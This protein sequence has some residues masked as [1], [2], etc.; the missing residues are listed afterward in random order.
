[1]SMS[2]KGLAKLMEEAGEVV[3]V[4]GKVLAYGLGEHPD[5]S[6]LKPRLEDEIADIE[7]ACMFV[8][9][10]LDLD[11][12]RIAE[13][14]FRKLNLFREWDADQNNNSHEMPR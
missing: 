2:H 11:E 6:L 3:Q 9:R 1:M 8:A 10:R 13:R 12:D 7:A 14:R 5:G 4:A